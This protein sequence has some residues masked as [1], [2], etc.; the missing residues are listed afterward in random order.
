MSG[1]AVTWAL[2]VELPDP[3][4]KLVLVALAQ[5]ADKRHRCFPG[6]VRLAQVSCQ[7]IEKATADLALLRTRK[8]IADTGERAGPNRRAIVWELGVNGPVEP[9][10]LSPDW[11]PPF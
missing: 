7:S 5:Y 9:G 1:E 2:G 4:T 8:L 3:G 6:R 10:A 11:V